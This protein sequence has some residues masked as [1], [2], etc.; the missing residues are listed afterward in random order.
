MIQQRRLELTPDQIAKTENLRVINI[1]MSFSMTEYK[2]VREQNKE[3]FLKLLDEDKHVEF[4]PKE[5][6]PLEKTASIAIVIFA[7]QESK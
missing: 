7:R 3:E 6:P 4:K 5:L 2:K 1:V